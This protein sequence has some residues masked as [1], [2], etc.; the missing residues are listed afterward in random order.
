MNTPSVTLGYVILYVQ[1]VP[2]SIAFYEK[3]FGLKQRFLHESQGYGEME[4]GATRLAFL[5]L[6]FANEVMPQKPLVPSPTS[7]PHASEIA[8]VTP[9]VAALYANAIAAGAHAFATPAEKPWGQTV[10]YVRD[11]DGHLVELCSP[12]P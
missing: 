7:A 11:P 9:D 8:L 1:S 6:N 3:A 2:A 10:G 4:T 5:A 12:L